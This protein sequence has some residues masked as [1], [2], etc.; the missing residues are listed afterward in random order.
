MKKFKIFQR[1]IE[2][3]YFSRLTPNETVAKVA[4][5][6]Q[7]EIL[8][9]FSPEFDNYFHI[10][11]KSEI[12]LSTSRS[13]EGSELPSMNV[14][15]LNLSFASLKKS[16]FNFLRRIKPSNISTCKI[17]LVVQE[18]MNRYRY[19]P[20]HNFAHSFS[21]MQIF[22]NFLNSTKKFELFDRKHMFTVY[23]ACL[24]H[25]MGH[26]G[27]NNAYYIAR[28]N[29]LSLLSMGTS[30]L[31]RYHASEI[32]DIISNNKTNIF[33]KYSQEDFGTAKKTLIEAILSTDMSK[34]FDI[35]KK[36]SATPAEEFP[37]NDN[38]LTGVIVHACDIG[39]ACLEFNNYF[40][41]VKLLL[42][43]F[44]NQTVSESRK[45]LTVSQFML[46]KGND[47][48]TKDQI[49]FACKVISDLCPSY[50]QND[51]REV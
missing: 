22:N 41:W 39:N 15:I 10:A 42:Q 30:V 46:Y 51:R 37:K 26:K 7:R 32:I 4:E 8:A 40:S 45:G 31:E 24:A 33:E 1:R 35:L 27:K 49:F 19:V 13:V 6:N 20:Y 25:D 2:R 21:L 23:I 5:F 50:F 29:K 16:A 36:F 44:N 38:F 28:K 34:H 43:E 17:E 12:E 9:S 11:Q 47:A 48:V 3:S 14:N 18:I